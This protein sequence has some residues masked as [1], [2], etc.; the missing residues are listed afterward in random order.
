MMEIELEIEGSLD[1]Q[2]SDSIRRSVRLVRGEFAAS[3]QWR[4]VIRPSE[5]RNEWDVGVRAPSGWQ[6]ASFSGPVAGLP[7]FVERTLRQ[8]ARMPIVAANGP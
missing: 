8:H 2:V 1:R 7:A 4:V 5:T 3:G 6:L